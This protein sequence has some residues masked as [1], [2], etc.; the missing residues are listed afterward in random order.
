MKTQIW[1]VWAK[2]SKVATENFERI[3]NSTKK[4]LKKVEKILKLLLRSLQNIITK[5]IASIISISSILGLILV[6]YIIRLIRNLRQEEESNVKLIKYLCERLDK[7]ETMVRS[8]TQ[9]NSLPRTKQ[10]STLIE[11]ILVS[12]G[13]SYFYRGTTTNKSLCID[14]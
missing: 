5:A 11:Y 13:N 3:I 7:L 10:Q 4:I 6:T 2:S 8:Q 1:K 12:M 14:D 9:E